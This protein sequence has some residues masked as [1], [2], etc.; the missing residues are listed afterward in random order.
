MATNDKH[1]EAA[2]AVL[3]SLIHELVKSRVLTFAAAQ[4]IFDQA[5]QRAR[6]TRDRTL[7]AAIVTMNSQ[8]DWDDASENDAAYH[9]G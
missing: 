4:D 6:L 9:R 2:A 3:Q 7:M 5:H 1:S 8:M